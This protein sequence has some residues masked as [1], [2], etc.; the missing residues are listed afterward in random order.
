MY[1]TFNCGVGMV[2]CVAQ[3]DK[4]AAL[5]QLNTAGH[6]AWE[7]GRIAAAGEGAVGEVEL[8]S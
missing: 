3:Q 8:L 1:R 7:I 6:K 2:I 4:A 5:A